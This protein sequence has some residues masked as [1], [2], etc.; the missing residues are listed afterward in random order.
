[1]SDSDEQINLI[2]RPEESDYYY[3]KIHKDTKNSKFELKIVKIEFNDH[4]CVYYKN[5]LIYEISYFN[6]LSWKF[7]KQIWGIDY[8]IRDKEFN[9]F[10]KLKNNESEIITNSIKKKINELIEFT[11]LNK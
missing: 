11:N 10:F 7:S 5:K 2:E 9:L 6:I 1:M 8:K 4:F 3:L